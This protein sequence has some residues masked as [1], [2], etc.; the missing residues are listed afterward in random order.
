[1]KKILWIFVGLIYG[2]FFFNVL[3]VVELFQLFK[4]GDTYL[5]QLGAGLMS[6]GLSIFLGIACMIAAVVFG[7][8]WLV[9]AIRAREIKI[10]RTAKLVLIPFYLVNFMYW[11]LYFMFPIIASRGTVIFIFPVLGVIYFPMIVVSVFTYFTILVTSLPIIVED[12]RSK[13]DN[14]KSSV[15]PLILLDLLVLGIIALNVIGGN[16]NMTQ[17]LPFWILFGLFAALNVWGF[18]SKKVG[19]RLINTLFLLTEV[20]DIICAP[21]VVHTLV[22]SKR[23]SER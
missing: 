12:W 10:N 14:V 23:T 3:T 11:Q 7:I 13:K 18:L 19:L 2:T 4:P 9:K 22:K 1:M 17:K 16:I 20:L 8:I 15:I 5:N 21:F 6:F